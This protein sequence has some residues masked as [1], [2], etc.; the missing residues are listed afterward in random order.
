M[1]KQSERKSDPK[2]PDDFAK[3]AKENPHM[4]TDKP[5]TLDMDKDMPEDMMDKED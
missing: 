2:K 4:F 1:D 3:W 5:D